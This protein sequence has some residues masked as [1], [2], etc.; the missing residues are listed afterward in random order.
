TNKHI[1]LCAYINLMTN[2]T[3]EVTQLHADICSALAD[4]RRILLLYALAEKPYTVNDLAKYLEISQPVT[5]RHL[6]ILRERGLV[7]ATRDGIN[8][9]Y[10]LNDHRLIDALDLLRDV[11]RDRIA[12]RANLI[13][14]L[15]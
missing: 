11:L 12:H 2:L 3:Q 5:S 14:E 4:P 9:E 1:H 10:S 8:V 6:K 13:V 15:K 7:N